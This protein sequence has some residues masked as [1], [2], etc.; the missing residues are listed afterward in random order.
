LTLPRLAVVVVHFGPE[1]LCRACLESLRQS[2]GV[3]VALWL[4][5]HN[6]RASALLGDLPVSLP[7]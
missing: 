1:A 2:I 5:D 6:P 7:G 3:S 4:V